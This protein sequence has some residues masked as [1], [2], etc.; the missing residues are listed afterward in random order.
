ML[1]VRLDGLDD[2]GVLHEQE[3]GLRVHTVQHQGVYC[4]VQLLLQ[5]GLKPQDHTFY[6]GH[7]RVH[8][9]SLHVR[10]RLIEIALVVLLGQLCA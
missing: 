6:L 2:V 7:G 9:G 5:T 3:W 8:F 1:Q 4:E 10:D